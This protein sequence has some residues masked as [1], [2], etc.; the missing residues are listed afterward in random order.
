MHRAALALVLDPAH[1]Y[2]ESSQ[3]AWTMS[4]TP[5]GSA[6]AYGFV[7]ANFD[8]LA[9]RAP[10]PRDGLVCLGS[11]SRLNRQHTVISRSEQQRKDGSLS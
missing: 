6:L 5:R 7:K 1:D 2:R 3:I 11:W 4:N 9:A 10:G 8:A